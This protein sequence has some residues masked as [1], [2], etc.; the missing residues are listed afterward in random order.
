[1]CLTCGC[2]DAHRKMGR[3]VTYED[4]QEIATGNGRTV[5]ET[6]GI[7]DKTAVSDRSDHPREYDRAPE[8]V[9]S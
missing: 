4:M 1:M 8:A 6:L 3:N 2:G 7:L 5:D 9:T